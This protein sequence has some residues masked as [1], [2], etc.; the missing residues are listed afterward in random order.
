M[1]ESI[2]VVLQRLE[3]NDPTLTSLKWRI[4]E[5]E[6][7]ISK[8]C[9]KLKKNTNL[10]KL[11]LLGNITNANC[12]SVTEVIAT[13]KT[14]EYLNLSQTKIG[15]KGLAKI[16]KSIS[17]NT[18]IKWLIL[19]GTKHPQLNDLGVASLCQG[20]KQNT[21][22]QRLEL[23]SFNIT[24]VGAGKVA[25][26]LATN[27][28][29]LESLKLGY[30][31]Y[32]NDGLKDLARSLKFNTHLKRFSLNRQVKGES[33]NDKGILFFCHVLAGNNTTL[34]QIC[35]GNSVIDMRSIT[36]MADLVQTSACHLK[37]LQ[38]PACGLTRDK[39]ILL[40]RA[41]KT[42]DC[43]V[44]SLD[45]SENSLTCDALQALFLPCNYNL[46]ELNLSSNKLGDEEVKILGEVLKHNH[47]LTKLLLLNNPDITTASLIV[48]ESSLETNFSLTIFSREPSDK[49]RGLVNVGNVYLDRNQEKATKIEEMLEKG[50]LLPFVTAHKRSLDLGGFNRAKLTDIA[51]TVKK[52]LRRSAKTPGSSSS[53]SGRGIMHSKMASAL[54]PEI[55][56]KVFL[57]SNKLTAMP[58]ELILFSHQLTTLDLANNNLS[59]IPGA[60]VQA[61]AQL[62]TLNLQ[63]NRLGTVP[64]E[65]FNLK[66][67]KYLLLDNN[68]LAF[69]PQRLFDCRSLRKVS[70]Q[71]NPLAEMA[72]AM[73]AIYGQINQEYV[74][75]SG[76][77]I[78]AI[79]EELFLG[80][81]QCIRSLNLSNN[82]LQSLPPDIENLSNLVELN[83]ANNN[84]ESLP[85]QLGALKSLSK[86]DTSGNPL[87]LLPDEIKR[88]PT[89][90][91]L[92]FL[93][94][95]KDGK[96]KVY[97]MKLMF[98]GE[99]NVGKTTLFNAISEFASK[100]KARTDEPER[101]VPLLDHQMDTVSTDGIEIHN[102]KFAKVAEDG[103]DL[104]VGCWDFAGQE[105]YYSTHAFFL[106]KRSVFL[107]LFN[108]AEDLE[109]T[110]RRVDYW[111]ASINS[112]TKKC[113]VIIVG[114]HRD[115]KRCSK[116][117]IKMIF[118]TLQ[119]SY[120]GLY[121]NIQAYFAVSNRTRK[122]V[123]EMLDAV[124]EVMLSQAH[125]GEEVPVS[126]TLVEEQLV[127]ARK[128]YS[129]PLMTLDQ[130]TEMAVKCGVTE[131][132]ITTALN[133]MHDLG[134]IVNFSG[135]SFR[136]NVALENL[137]ILDPSWI[138]N[139]FRS[140]VTTKANFVTGGVIAHKNL[141]QIWR[142]PEYPLEIH[143][144][145]L[146]ILEKCEISYPLKRGM[147]DGRSLIA[148]LLPQEVPPPEDL[149][150]E[151]WST[152]VEASTKKR[153]IIAR[154][155]KLEFLPHGLFSRFM[156]RSLTVT[157]P[158]LYWN[159][160]F[161]VQSTAHGL[162]TMALLEAHPE[163]NTIT[164][165]VRGD[166][167][168]NLMTILDSSLFNLIDQWFEV[169]CEVFAVYRWG[170]KKD[171]MAL[172]PIADLEKAIFSGEE[173]Y[174]CSSAPGGQVDLSLVVPDL[175]LADLDDCTIS[176]DDLKIGKEIGEGGNA[177]VYWGTYDEKEVAIKELKL[178]T[179]KGM[180]EGTKEKMALMVFT[181]FRAEAW[182]MKLLRH[183]N[184]VQMAGITK[185]PRCLV[186]EF[187]K[188]G[189]L[190]DIMQRP[191]VDE[192]FT[193]KLRMKVIVDIAKGVE[194]MHSLSPQIIH[195]DLKT[196]NVLMTSLDPSKRIVAK[197]ADF[198]TCVAST[199]FIGRVVDN[200]LWLAP[201]IMQGFEYSEKA[202]IYSFA[203]IMYE[204]LT[205][206][207]PFDEYDYRFVSKL[208][209]QIEQGLRPT[210]PPE[211]TPFEYADLMRESW[212]GDPAARPEAQQLRKRLQAMADRISNLPSDWHDEAP[213]SMFLGDP[214]DDP[215]PAQPPPNVISQKN[216]APV[217]VMSSSSQEMARS[218]SSG[219]L[220]KR[221]SNTSSNKKEERPIPKLLQKV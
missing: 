48:V 69:L 1:T 78:V 30:N 113:P 19:S 106:S 55:K 215:E 105:L 83:I 164:I 145:L 160:G 133:F 178:R 176:Y 187:M 118:S 8:I 115:D 179:K 186:T 126:F 9:K 12:G 50:R 206:K 199:S 23:T 170:K 143:S 35:F 51:K 182:I 64:I 162:T 219:K 45:L 140:I 41:L 2:K 75:L 92:N 217:K 185:K 183:P 123:K 188:E 156:V 4:Y 28:P 220:K 63:C 87:S 213:Y 204:I 86:L 157:E 214:D 104:Q 112:K 89:R 202:D 135:K 184:I 84:I 37:S 70:V 109:Y 180:S 119:S 93:L 46:Q 60:V 131:K 96:T 47:S 141:P 27:P 10:T 110:K 11:Y 200:P 165:K 95:L 177:I 205:R 197:V 117:R 191:D 129:P 97:R 32:G 40:A 13:T 210:I 3:Q 137:L 194:F 158:K 139:V 66:N 15:S 155:Y 14:I 132:G 190:Y 17:T 108:L 98:V 218:G 102:L 144:A 49:G 174:P 74:D 207:L 212:Q 16:G 39:V 88:K 36:A 90:E 175:T 189:S 100:R 147:E 29:Q 73:A 68:E 111:L 72:P 168:A 173:M 161:L 7:V 77:G 57:Y 153:M 82:V 31:T 76:I 80:N 171:E 56:D 221:K 91:L 130:F 21:T 128:V 136:S 138:S 201:E 38:F 52:E 22:V 203:M 195:R 216:V 44:T 166:A 26:Y 120:S 34:E 149:E 122:G 59:D 134:I 121:N 99:E 192:F 148:T 33:D 146:A 43:R 167:P 127:V 85:W 163:L 79:P 25:A 169:E 114:T 103:S 198:G 181:E 172:L 151:G 94:E 159:N 6:S 209:K 142:P 67:L 24:N 150:N 152:K 62:E 211:T 208:E 196:L 5:D 116:E 81:T 53:G 20:L 101:S 61:L 65:L 42:S 125:M 18:S 124:L 54:S 193:W 71:E 154:I 58:Q 107:L